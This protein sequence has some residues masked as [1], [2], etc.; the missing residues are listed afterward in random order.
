MG[1]NQIRG[2]PMNSVDFMWILWI[3]TWKSAEIR[4]YISFGPVIKYSLLLELNLTAKH[5]QVSYLA[6]QKC[7]LS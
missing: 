5:L 2:F 1:F 7:L 6:A 4:G 3:Q